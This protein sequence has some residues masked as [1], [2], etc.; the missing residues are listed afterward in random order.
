MLA[1]IYSPSIC[2]RRQGGGASAA[3]PPSLPYFPLVRPWR[4][5][6][7]KQPVFL[8]Y[9]GCHG[10]QAGSF[11]ALRLLQLLSPQCV[12]KP[13]QRRKMA[14]LRQG[15]PRGR[16]KGGRGRA[17]GHPPPYLQ[18]VPRALAAGPVGTCG[19]NSPCFSPM[20]ASSAFKQAVSRRAGSCSFDRLR[21]RSNQGNAGRWRK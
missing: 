21:A 6:V 20:A 15:A 12:I 10:L 17:A 13:R 1:I 4:D 2:V 9:G 8:T 11:T 19:D 18:P 5:L 3:I 16:R 14:Q 7:E